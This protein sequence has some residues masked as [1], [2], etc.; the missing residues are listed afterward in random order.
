M[1]HQLIELATRILEK[2]KGLAKIEPLADDD[3]PGLDAP[4]DPKD[5]QAEIRLA[6]FKNDEQQKIDER[7]DTLKAITEIDPQ[8]I[9]EM[10]T[11][12]AERLKKEAND[13]A[14]LK[15]MMF[16]IDLEVFGIKSFSSAV[17]NITKQ[18]EAIE[19]VK[20]A[21]LVKI[22]KNFTDLTPIILEKYQKLDLSNPPEIQT[23]EPIG[24]ASKFVNRSMFEIESA[25]FYIQ[26]V[27]SCVKN[28]TKAA[29][30]RPMTIESISESEKRLLIVKAY[31]KNELL[32][33]KFKNIVKYPVELTKL[34]KTRLQFEQINKADEHRKQQFLQDKESAARTRKE[35]MEAM[36]ERRR[37][38]D[39]L[40]A[41]QLENTRFK[42]ATKLTEEEYL[43]DKEA[44][45]RIL[46]REKE[47]EFLK[48]IMLG[49]EMNVSAVRV[50]SSVVTNVIDATK[51]NID[52]IETIMEEE[53][54]KVDEEMPKIIKLLNEKYEKLDLREET[55]PFA[56]KRG[57]VKVPLPPERQK[58]HVQEPSVLSQ[59]LIP[60]A[61][62]IAEL[63]EVVSTKRVKEEPDTV[64][65][66][67]PTTL[68]RFP[69]RTEEEALN[70][71]LL[72]IKPKETTRPPGFVYQPK[73]KVKASA[74][75]KRPIQITPQEFPHYLEQLRARIYDTKIFFTYLNEDVE[76]IVEF[77][78]EKV[79]SS[80]KQET[81]K[82]EF[83]KGIEDIVENYEKKEVGESVNDEKSI[84]K[85][86]EGNATVDPEEF[87]MNFN[88]IVLNF[89]VAKVQTE[90]VSNVEEILAK[91]EKVSDEI[92]KL[93]V[94]NPAT[95]DATQSLATPAL[96]KQ[97]A[98]L[99]KQKAP[100][101]LVK[102]DATQT[103]SKQAKERKEKEAKK[104]DQQASLKH[105][106]DAAVQR[107]KEL[108]ALKKEITQTERDKEKEALRILQQEREKQTLINEERRRA[109]EPINTTVA[110]A[111]QNI[112]SI[113][114]IVDRVRKTTKPLLIEGPIVLRR[115]MEQ[116]NKAE[117][118]A[119]IARI[120]HERELKEG[121]EQRVADEK[122]IQVQKEEAARALA[123]SKLSAEQ[124]EINRKAKILE[125][126]GIR[127]AAAKAQR[128]RDEQ[129]KTTRD[130]D[131]TTETFIDGALYTF[132][133]E[134]EKDNYYLYYENGK[135][136]Q[137]YD[138]N[139]IGNK[140]IK[141][142][143]EVSY[144]QTNP[145]SLEYPNQI[146]IPA[147]S[148]PLKGRPT[149]LLKK[150]KTY[151]FIMSK[152]FTFRAKYDGGKQFLDSKLIKFRGKIKPMQDNDIFTFTYNKNKIILVKGETRFDLY[153]Q[154]PFPTELD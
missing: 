76:E 59:P 148:I 17:D 10:K 66:R 140:N 62:R 90:S 16:G 58:A 56:E 15:K 44:K 146:G 40:K 4:V 57:E 33:Q 78:E 93:P 68:L 73:T 94:I 128:E 28:I 20:E 133:P 137:K 63:E 23:V 69:K 24:E 83:V 11:E 30:D 120:R 106:K 138:H 79:K 107:E 84:V 8:K 53:M 35:E 39:A 88:D 13:V 67:E 119:D 91:T 22:E 43:L 19:E 85:K 131:Y 130:A 113:K 104:A 110:M 116:E 151:E 124:R 145:R 122:M 70:R 89:T 26:L 154:E 52:P 129:E 50:I 86:D 72:S 64:Q 61:K 60:N 2:R 143:I 7:T 18:P 47:D 37:L 126:E 21:E 12:T 153:A 118:D 27:S 125:D 102:Q 48:K 134:D 46:K 147:K 49:I 136:L 31:K 99:M 141:R 149:L 108:L 100:P 1:L 14:N 101:A 127:K 36:R 42:E 6:K 98:A 34:A 32:Q 9:A 65:Q 121:E 45:E 96:V 80:N 152:G 38:E 51:K 114:D 111:K 87:L 135:F 150:D 3:L 74:V 105:I 144:V 117:A 123:E 92:E 109:N 139:G 81:A 5:I 97:E 82:P 71:K 95:Q 29:I 25:A 115:R 41:T 77:L 103:L 55:I 112:Q 75:D 132:E 54:K 142:P